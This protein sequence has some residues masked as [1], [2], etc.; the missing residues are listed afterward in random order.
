MAKR[1]IPSMYRTRLTRTLGGWSQ[2]VAPR[3][4]LVIAVALIAIVA[5]AIGLGIQAQLASRAN[6]ATAR[7]AL[8]QYSSVAAWQFTQRT[9]REFQSAADATIGHR[10]GRALQTAAHVRGE[11]AT[12]EELRASARLDCQCESPLNAERFFRWDAGS[13]D[14][15]V[16]GVWPAADRTHLAARLAADAS[17]P[18]GD[19]HLSAERL[20]QPRDSS[21]PHPFGRWSHPN[22]DL[23][24]DVDR[25]GTPR[26]LAVVA[27]FDA[28]RQ[29]RAVYGAIIPIGE[30]QSLFARAVSREPLLPTALLSAAAQDSAVAI[31]VVASGHEIF[32]RGPVSSADFFATDSLGS[33]T[34]GSVVRTGLRADIADR[35]FIGGLPRSRQPMIVVL[36]GLS[37]LL[38]T[39]ALR[40]MRRS[41]DLARLRSDFVASVSHEL[42][43][44]LSLVRVYTETLI[45]DTEVDRAKRGRFLG[46]I[47]KETNRLDR[48]VENLLRFADLERRS[49]EVTK[50]P[51]ELGGLLTAALEDF[52]PLAESAS[53]DLVGNIVCDL[54]AAVD[55]AALRQMIFNLLT[56][57]VKFGGDGSRVVVAL[58][59]VDDNARILVD[60]EGP[61]IPTSQRR[62][63]FDRY[64]RL[65]DVASGGPAGSGLGL[66]IVR[67]LAHAQGISAWIDASPLGGTRVVLLM[68]L[69]E[70]PAQNEER[71]ASPAGARA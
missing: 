47:L 3:E 71:A 50:K 15:V 22:C 37:L 61:G 9:Q 27:S 20:A 10:V 65:A 38:L 59:R 24:I 35:L 64:V 55:A 23:L 29:L 70:A 66:A 4:M 67:E 58:D 13:H 49:I 8:E 18:L 30:A 25:N 62:R 46:V 33:T 32:A 36:L 54:V 2:S 17:D 69:L 56:N 57:A 52:R 45:D 14:V 60:D 5:V 48:M 12:P 31:S 51:T 39:I 53:V 1:D 19:S 11:L 7:R 43:T 63:V 6:V 44:P 34:F 68:P 41:A 21:T 40:Q 28:S 26:L 42:R 16:E